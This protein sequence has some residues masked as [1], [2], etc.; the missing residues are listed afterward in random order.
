MKQKMKT[1]IKEYIIDEYITCMFIITLITLFAFLV[2]IN[3]EEIVNPRQP[4]AISVTG[5]PDK[6]SSTTV[7]ICKDGSIWRKDIYMG[8]TDG[9]LW[10]KE[11]NIPEVGSLL[12][13][14][15]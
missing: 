13:G 12:D 11:M 2:N 7:V 10:R 14:S 15:N 1:I 3:D 8:M 5:N 4:V 9:G 6:G